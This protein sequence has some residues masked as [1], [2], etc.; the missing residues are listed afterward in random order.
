MMTT[1][2]EIV[3]PDR[4][5]TLFW[6]QEKFSSVTEFSAFFPRTTYGGPFS[7]WHPPV[8]ARGKKC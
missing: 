3:S 4:D 2:I 5:E 1:T 8:N 6:C 7:N